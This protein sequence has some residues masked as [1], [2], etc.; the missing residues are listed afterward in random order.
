MTFI[1]Q[2]RESTNSK[3]AAYLAFISGRQ[4]EG[5][6]FYAFVEDQ[7]D[8]EFYQH[9]LP[10]DLDIYYLTCGGKSEIF[11][12]HKK[13]SSDGLLG[14]CLFFCDRDTEQMPFK[15]EHE[16]FRTK[17]YSWES[18]CLIDDILELVACR[19]INP[20]LSNNEYKKFSDSWQNTKE[21]F[22]ALMAEQIAI[23]VLEQSIHARIGASNWIPIIDARNV[24]GVIFPS[25]RAKNNLAEIRENL[26]SEGVDFA[27]LDYI[28]NQ[29]TSSDKF[30]IWRGKTAF[31]ILKKF[32]KDFIKDIGR[33]ALID[34]NSPISFIKAAPSTSHHFEDIRDYVKRRKT[35]L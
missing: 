22:C 35:A 1:D 18:Y 17:Y 27:L 5:Y 20:M 8:V 2:L 29:H 31:Q 4:R 21:Q 33:I 16:I 14:E 10:N 13:I 7:D 30:P 6:N 25:D 19:K 11:S 34:F 23:I 3:H 26:V 24:D 32:T 15:F 28:A 9:A 12:I